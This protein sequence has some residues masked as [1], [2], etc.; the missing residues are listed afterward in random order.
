MGIDAS[1]WGLAAMAAS[2][3]VLCALP[4]LDS[5]PVASIRYRPTWHRWLDSLF[6]VVFVFLGLVGGWPAQGLVIVS[7]QIATVLYFAFFLLMPWWSRKGAFRSVP[8]RLRYRAQADRAN[9]A[10]PKEP[11]AS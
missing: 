3:L 6:A 1:F 4:W 7:G 2:I 11:I 5:S 9:H 8:K 10:V